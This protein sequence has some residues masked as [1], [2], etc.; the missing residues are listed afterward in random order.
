MI[1]HILSTIIILILLCNSIKAQNRKEVKSSPKFIDDIEVA[2]E[3]IKT[4]NTL[5]NN[6]IVRAETVTVQKAIVS[7][8][9]NSLEVASLL[10]FKYSLLLNTEVEL[11]KNISLFNLI[12]DWFGTPYRMGGTSKSGIDCSAFV[13]IMYS[14]LFGLM[15][16]RTAREQYNVTRKIS[17]TELKEGDLVFFNTR[18]GISH[19]GLYLQNNKFVHAASS[20]GVM[21]SDLYD[22]YWVKRFAGVGRYEKGEAPVFFSQP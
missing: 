7:D 14:G 5:E 12:D 8:K 21:I 22:D 9:P 16:P 20:G 13:Q 3:P 2:F 15:L 17:R 10:Q 18:G 4:E 19:V 11:I 6:R 1:K